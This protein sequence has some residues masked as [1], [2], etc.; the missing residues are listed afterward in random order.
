MIRIILKQLYLIFILLNLWTLNVEAKRLPIEAYASLPEISYVKLS[1]D[2]MKIAALLNI[3]VKN[4]IKTAVSIIDLS[5]GKETIPVLTDNKK[6]ILN[7]LTWANNDLLLIAATYPE[8]WSGTKITESRLL[9]YHLKTKKIGY[10]LSRHFLKRL[11]YIPQN[12]S[13]I[14]DILADEKNYILMEIAGHES[15]QE[16]SVVKIS[17]G[18][19]KTR[20]IQP[21]KKHIVNWVLDQ[22][23]RVRIGIYRKESNYIIYQLT[24][25]AKMKALWKFPAFSRKEVWPLGFGSDPDELYVKAL[26]DD[27]MAI[28]KVNLKSPTLE[29]ILVAKSNHTIDKNLFF[30]GSVDR[31]NGWEKEYADIEKNLNKALPGKRNRIVSFSAD[32]KRYIVYSTSST[33]PGI[34]LLGDRKKN[35]LMKISE[36]YPA[37]KSAYLYQKKRIEYRAR[38]GLVINGYLTLPDN[39]EKRKLA[40]IIFPHGGPISF[41][42]A[43]FDYWT[44]FFV[45]RNYAVL[46]M[47]FRGSSGYGYEFMAAG[48]KGWGLAMQDDVEDATK[49]IINKGIAD[50]KKICIVGGSYGGYA[51]LMAAVKT[52][53]LYQCAISIAG[54]SDLAYMVRMGRRFNSYDVLKKQVG[55]DREQLRKTSPVNFA[56]EI[57]IPILLIHGN[58]DRVVNVIQSQKMRDALKKSHK[59]FQYIELENG[60][61][62][63]NNNENRIK[64]FK[65]MAAF[66]R[67][68]LH[69]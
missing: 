11:K 19:G 35:S 64:T 36:Q 34:F 30:S 69:P 38:D 10:V 43:D 68:Y 63:L 4:K 26:K 65:A 7:A 9:K 53:D 1:P 55:E 32:K 42:D 46:Q 17:L 66:L 44:Q 18:K 2:G 67:K 20:Y 16:P 6:F 25:K 41:D 27:N 61:H 39:P 40:T 47:N 52:P 21:A 31:F 23:H 13:K 54:V 45:S 8:S 37:L 15:A 57:K 51:A 24:D 33:S 58:K 28:Y 49:W 56:D 48:L 22:Q 14:I 62:H 12:Q 3:K 60:D 59:K 5:T 29:K 50:P